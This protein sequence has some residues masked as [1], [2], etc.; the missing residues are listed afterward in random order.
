M[1]FVE[2]A[3]VQSEVVPEL[4]VSR[5]DEGATILVPKIPVLLNEPREHVIELLIRDY[6]HEQGVREPVHWYY[7]PM[8]IEFTTTLP[9][10]LIV[11]DCMDEL[12]A[13]RGAPP[14]LRAAEDKLLK[15]ADIVFTGGRTLHQS[16]RLL[17]P[18]VHLFPSSIDIDHFKRARVR[19]GAP[20]DQV[21]LPRPRLGY[22][23]VLDERLDLQLLSDMALLRPGWQFIMLG[24]VAKIDSSELPRQ[25]NISY[26][27]M[28]DYKA[29][30]AYLAGWDIAMLP[31]ARNESTQFISP[32]KTPEYLAAGLPTISTSI[33]DVVSPYGDAGLVSIADDASTFVNTAEHLLCQSEGGRAEWQDRV[34]DFLSENSWDRTWCAMWNLVE[35]TRHH[36]S[37]LAFATG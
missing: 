24:P 1:F 11:Y 6:L 36:R 9:C 18:N 32:T 15:R 14:G 17:H 8:A 37:G 4:G 28:K 12:S 3:I 29:L 5:S 30:P 25:P 7:A 16:K 21:D 33:P 23:G 34:D 22:C 19:G 31:F 2:E 35:N 10:S 13:F 20:A 26:L 27:G